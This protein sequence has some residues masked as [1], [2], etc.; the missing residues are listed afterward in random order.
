MKTV[1]YLLF[2]ALAFNSCYYPAQVVVFNKSGADK[3]IRVLYPASH[4]AVTS[5]DSLQAYDLTLTAN[6]FSSRDYYRYGLKI[7][8][9]N[10][11][12]AN[13][14]FSFTLK[15]KHQ[16]IVESSWPVST[17][18]W[19]QT[20]IINSADTVVLKRN[21]RDI[22]FKRKGGNWVYVLK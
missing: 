20:F 8:L 22:G 12:T 4:P 3:N 16:V 9:E 14:S 7:P 1:A 17:L 6:A 18:S 15:D 21:G 13:R 19:G 5:N 11:D 10:L 2:I